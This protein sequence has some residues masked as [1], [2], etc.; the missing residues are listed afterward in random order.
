M[1]TL[2]GALKG[3]LCFVFAIIAAVFLFGSDKLNIVNF[4]GFLFFAALA[5][6]LIIPQNKK[7]EKELEKLRGM[8]TDEQRDALEVQK[9]LEDQ[10]QHAKTEKASIDAELVTAKNSLE[11]ARKELQSV[12]QSIVETNEEVLLQSFNLYT[13]HYDFMRAEA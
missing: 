3:V 10:I 4:I 11:T 6:M 2:K 13:P 9:E 8:L 5:T 1:D 7:Q 12:K